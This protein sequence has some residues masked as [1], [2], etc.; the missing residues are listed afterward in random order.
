V[1]RLSP[2]AEGDLNDIIF[3]S[4]NHFGAGTARR[5]QQR[6]EERFVRI[7][8][9][10]VIGHIRADVPTSLPLRFDVVRPFVIA[11]EPETKIIIRVLHGAR[12]FGTIFSESD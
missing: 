4:E 12:D 6:L 5:L 2:E 1:Y 10:R 9:G 3:Y 11:F 7:A 8:E